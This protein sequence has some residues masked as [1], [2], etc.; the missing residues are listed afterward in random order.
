MTD[1]R[2]PD[3]R[4]PRDEGVDAAWEAL[5]R[6]MYGDIERNRRTVEH[7][8][9]LIEAALLDRLRVA[10]PQ[11]LDS[12]AFRPLLSWAEDVSQHYAMLRQEPPFTSTQTLDAALDSAY[13]A[14]NPSLSEPVFRE[15]RT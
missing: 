8:R 10:P 3:D 7:Y 5:H 13:R 6:E 12:E 14:L 11:P 2:T 4:L 1:Q 9:P 15:P